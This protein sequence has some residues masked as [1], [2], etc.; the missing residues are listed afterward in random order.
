MADRAGSVHDRMNRLGKISRKQNGQEPAG[1][2][3]RCRHQNAGAEFVPEHLFSRLQA[4]A[5][6]EIALALAVGRHDR[7]AYFQKVC[8]KFRD[9]IF[10]TESTLARSEERRVGKECR[11]RWSPYH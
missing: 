7:T 2:Q 3:T 4:E 6:F 8:M 9:P 1:E 5:D 11:S 10:R